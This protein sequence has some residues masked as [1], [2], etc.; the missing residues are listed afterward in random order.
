MRHGTCFRRR[1]STRHAG[2]APHSAVAELGVV[3]RRYPF[4]IMN[5]ISFTLALMSVLAFA[6]PPDAVNARFA[7]ERAIAAWSKGK[8]TGHC[9]LHNRDM[10]RKRVPLAYGNDDIA[11]GDTIPAMVRI[12]RFPHAR[13]YAVSSKA[14]QKRSPKTASVFVCADCQE[15][16]KR[17]KQENP[18]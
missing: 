2:A 16:E 1:L 18:Q 12:M 13:E 14:E 8:Q 15:A 5:L 9:L 17:W 6:G 3:R 10:V 11:G 7:E 4:V